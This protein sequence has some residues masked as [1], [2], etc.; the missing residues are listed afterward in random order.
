VAVEA[1]VTTTI[2]EVNPEF[3]TVL[4][5]TLKDTETTENASREGARGVRRGARYHLATSGLGVITGTK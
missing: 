2:P 4:T 5:V 3:Q 1:V